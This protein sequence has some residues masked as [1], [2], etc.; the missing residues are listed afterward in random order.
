ML[1][2]K[3]KSQLFNLYHRQTI[4]SSLFTV[5]DLDPQMGADLE[6]TGLQGPH[7]YNRL[8]IANPAFFAG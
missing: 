1:F 7:P 3:T 6:E 4:F 5:T 2:R 8:V